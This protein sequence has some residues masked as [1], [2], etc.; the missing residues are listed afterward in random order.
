MN[1]QELINIVVALEQDLADFYERIEKEDQ[2]RKIG[3]VLKYMHKHSAIHAELIRNHLPEAGVPKL[4]IEP[5]QTLHTRIKSALFQQLMDTDDL[6]RACEQLA[7]AE[8]LIAQAY[9]VIAAHCQKVAGVYEKLGHKFK[10]L[11]DDEM[12]HHDQLLKQ[13]PGGD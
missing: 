11:A 2:F 5:L 9:T 8:A 7:Q 10:S 6:T 13:A 1:P 3:D 12:Q 4:N